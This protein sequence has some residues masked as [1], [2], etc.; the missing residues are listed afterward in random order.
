MKTL[1]R[2]DLNLLLTLHVLL[3][4][5]H[6]SRAAIRLHKSQP[7]ISHAL[8]QLRTHL[9]D[10]LLIR[11]GATMELTAY[12]QTLIKPL[13]DTLHILDQLISNEPIPPNKIQRRFRLAM[14]DYASAIILPSLIHHLRHHAPH[15]QLAIKQLSRAEMIAQ[16]ANGELDLAFSPFIEHEIP[17]NI[18]IQSL[19]QEH[20]ICVTDQKNLPENG[21]LTFEQWHSRPHVLTVPSPDIAFEIERAVA[22][23]SSE[24]LNIITATPHWLSA[25]SLLPDTDLILTISSRII[26]NL[27]AYP[28]LRRFPFPLEHP[29]F[30]YYQAWHQRKESDHAHRYLRETIKLLHTK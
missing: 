30:L 6:I 20:F 29:P 25:L 21:Q 16:L 28:T 5:K 23:R 17:T 7:A 9:N 26:S 13:D 10:P 18:H 8:A 22:Q 15:I 1:R 4:E 27:E 11:K 24:K 3:S 2:I 14:S 12:A 19:F